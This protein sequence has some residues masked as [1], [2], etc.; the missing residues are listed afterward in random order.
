MNAGKNQTHNRWSIRLPRMSKRIYALVLLLISLS[1]FETYQYQ[2]LVVKYSELGNR[3]KSLVSDLAT[4]QSQLMFVNVSLNRSQYMYNR[5]LADYSR[6]QIIY[7]TPATNESITIWILPQNLHPKGSARLGLLDTFVNHVRIHTNQTVRFLV[8]S[9]DDY[10]N[11]VNGN[12]YVA[13]FDST[14]TY[15][16]ADIHLTQG[17]AAYILVIVNLQS[18]ATAV[19]P[20]VTATYAPTPFL[21]GV[22]SLP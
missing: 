21:T 14:S 19:Y 17:C 16:S 8:L 5:L 9:I 22:C 10:V 6:T 2:D 15:F 13:A 11:F 7:R 20:N 4:L 12:R 1:L 18:S 3:Y